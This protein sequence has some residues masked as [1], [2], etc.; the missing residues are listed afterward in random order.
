[1]S[2]PEQKSEEWMK[3]L[4]CRFWKEEEIVLY[5]CAGTLAASKAC[6]Q[7]PRMP[8]DCRWS[9]QLRFFQDALPALVELYERHSMSA[10]S[11]IVEYEEAVE[12]RE[13]S[14]NKMACLDSAK[15]ADS[16]NTP[17]KLVPVRLFS[18][19]TMH[20]LANVCENLTTLRQ[21]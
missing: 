10:E 16:W 2:R 13:V 3:Y 6:L 9:Q 19:H 5:T 17:A 12:A 8:M 4:V 1:M 7:L 14:L 21:G 20:F 18:V 15:W 11:G